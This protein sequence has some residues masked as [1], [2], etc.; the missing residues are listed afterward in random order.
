M[1]NYRINFFQNLYFVILIILFI[2]IF[3]TPVLIKD[4][5]SVFEEETVE[6]L[7]L[8]ILSIV[9]FIVYWLYRRE[10]TRNKKQFD[11]VVNYLGKINVQIENL[12]SVFSDI[13]KYP[14]N[15][16]D[17]KYILDSLA[18]KVLGITNGDW[19]F[20]RVIELLT[21]KTL[22]E[23]SKAR[24]KAVLFKSEISNK[25]LA[26]G[27]KIEGCSVVG[28]TA[29]NFNIRAFCVVP[30]KSLTQHQEFLLKSIT[31]NVSM[32]YLIFASSYYKDTHLNQ[33]H[34]N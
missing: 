23:Y 25:L 31:E 28:S 18:D 10:L 14:E 4:G 29:E 9:T 8:V 15:K 12:H 2:F 1:F 34:A 3:F 20:F 19:V 26:N 33:S 32:L 13:N 7:T 24:G 17:L 16:S 27:E 11:E 6:V 30:V 22:T 21:L 5:F